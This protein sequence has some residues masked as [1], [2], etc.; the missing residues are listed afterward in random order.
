M[1]QLSTKQTWFRPAAEEPVRQVLREI[2]RN[3]RAARLATGLTQEEAAARA[4]ID[5]KRWQM[6]ERGAANVTVKTL[7]RMA[8]ATGVTVWRVFSIGG[9]GRRPSSKLT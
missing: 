5:Y 9:R 7:A 6:I 2:G 3:I 8:G 4:K 1:R